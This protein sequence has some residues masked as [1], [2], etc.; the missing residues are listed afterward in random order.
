MVLTVAFLLLSPPLLSCAADEQTSLGQAETKNFPPPAEGTLIVLNKAEATA[1]LFDLRNGRIVA[2]LPTGAGPHEAA[3]SPSGKTAVAC[4]YGAQQPGSTLTVINVEAAKVARTIDLAEYRRPHGIEFLSE[5]RIVVTCEA[6][7]ALVIVNLAS[8]R[9]E[10]AIETGQEVSHM[11]AVTPDAKRAFVANIGSGSVTALDLLEGK[12][13]RDISTG[14][15]AEGIA[16]SPDGKEVWVTNRGADTVSIV[17][18]ESLEV[19]KTLQSPQFPIRVKITPDGKRA[20]VSNA[21]S[22]TVTVFD[23]KT[24]ERL[25]LVEMRLAASDSEGRLFGGQFGSSSVPIGILIHP[26]GKWA[27]VANANAD[28]ITVLDVE[29]MKIVGYLATGREPDGMAHSQIRVKSGA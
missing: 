4:N 5:E 16:M 2:T 11:V 24:K 8:G 9:V 26:S 17:N 3:V 19:V 18:A 29:A 22:A 10:G 21:R 15:G 23:A 6:N 28:L 12:K 14:A 7:R 13:L 20:L 1:S 25:G 27:Y